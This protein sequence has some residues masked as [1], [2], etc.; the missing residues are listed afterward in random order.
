MIEYVTPNAHPGASDAKSIQNAI[1]HAV[2]TGTR[3]VAV[4]RD[5]AQRAASP[6]CAKELPLTGARWKPNKTK[7]TATAVFFVYLSES[8][9][10][11]SE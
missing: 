7:K 1:D 3:R 11:P 8:R 2:A 9:S 6:L 10:I 4:S 5:F